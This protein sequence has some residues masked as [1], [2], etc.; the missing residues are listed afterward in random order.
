VDVSVTSGL[1][2]RQTA[3]TACLAHG[4]Q[5]GALL[6]GA[7]VGLGEVAAEHAGK[8]G[9]ATPVFARPAQPVGKLTATRATATRR[10]GCAH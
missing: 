7:S 9:R 5:V 2:Y 10:S 8:P 4:V 1:V 6:E 3:G